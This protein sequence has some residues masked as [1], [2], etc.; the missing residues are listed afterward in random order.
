[1]KEQAENRRLFTLGSL[2]L[3][4]DMLEPLGKGQD[5]SHGFPEN[6]TGQESEPTLRLSENRTGQGLNRFYYFL[7]VRTS[8]GSKLVF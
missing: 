2:T 7:E 5:Q 3:F 8:Q 4:C 1:M 6:R